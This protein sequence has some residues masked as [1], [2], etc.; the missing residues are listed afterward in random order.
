ML[1]VQTLLDK[2]SDAPFVVLSDFDGSVPLSL[3]YL[4]LAELF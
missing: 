2:Y 1:D 3:P 4:Q